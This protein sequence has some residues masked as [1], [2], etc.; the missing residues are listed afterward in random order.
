MAS[1]APLLLVSALLAAEGPEGLEVTRPSDESHE[2]TSEAEAGRPAEAPPRAPRLEALRVPPPALLRTRVAAKRPVSLLDDLDVSTRLDRITLSLPT[3]ASVIWPQT[4][5]RA[6]PRLHTDVG[7]GGR[8]VV[9]GVVEM[10]AQ[11]GATVGADATPRHDAGRNLVWSP[12][13]RFGLAAR[14]SER[15]ELAIEVTRRGPLSFD[16]RG[17]EARG[18]ANLRWRFGR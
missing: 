3:R 8:T 6:T 12:T 14:P 13:S 18:M 17:D 15:V 11:G 10:Y 7:V 16:P 2:T 9:L 1:F 5:P 4:N